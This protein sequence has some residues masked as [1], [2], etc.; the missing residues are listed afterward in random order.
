[1]RLLTACMDGDIVII[2]APEK[3]DPQ[4][5]LDKL[6]LTGCG[7]VVSFLGIT[8]HYDDGKEIYRLEFDAWQE[9]LGSV[10][11]GLAED[12]IIK[13]GVKK[14]AMSHR[15]GSV[16][17]GENI[18]SIHVASPHRK[19]AF[20]A[21]EW[22]IDE[23]KIQAPIWKKEVS[24]IGETWKAG[25]GEKMSKEI[26]AVVDISEKQVVKRKATATGILRLNQ[27]SI[28]AIKSKLVKK[29]DV[30]EASTIAAIQAVKETPRIIPHCHPIPIEGCKVDWQLTRES[31]TL[32][33]VTVTAHYKT[34]IEMEAITGVC[35]GL[36][37]AL[38]MVK[39]YEKDAEGQYPDSQ[40]TEVRIIEKYK[41]D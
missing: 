14:V 17:A 38:D 40:I 21:C 32:Y 16:K 15:T 13:F 26:T 6:N 12:V 4:S 2:E 7:A 10:L 24:N 20:R 41:S 27:E 28:S 33:R 18:V 3:L 11:Y 29:G 36:L 25:L 8:R 30:V 19:E 9:K 31:F 23:L 1:M 22:L 39:S 37:C 5:L 35:A 34:G